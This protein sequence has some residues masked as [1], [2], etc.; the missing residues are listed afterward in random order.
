MMKYLDIPPFWLIGALSLAWIQ[1][2]YFDFGLSLDF[3]VVQMLGGLLVGGGI[4]LIALATIEFFKHKT[5]IIPHQTAERLITQ[6][7][8]KRSRNPIYLGDALILLG[9]ILR[10]DSV[11]SLSLLPIFVWVIEN[12]FILPEEDRLRRKF[13]V[14]FARYLTQTRRWI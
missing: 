5:T 6:G 2:Q 1:G 11:L 10:W 8:F 4:I 7:I 9:L 12:R 13:R 14:E 3:P